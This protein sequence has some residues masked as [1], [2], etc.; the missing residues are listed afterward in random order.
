MSAD[1]APHI[2]V[3]IAVYVGTPL[4]YQKYRHTA[5]CFRPSNREAPMIIHIVGPNMDYQLETRN[6]YEPTSSRS[7]AKEVPVGWIRTP[8]TKAQLAPL[9]YQTPINNTS[10]EFNCQTWVGDVLRRLVQAGYLTR[11]DCENG[12][13]GMIDAT[14][15]AGDE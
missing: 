7:F 11:E 6:N 14:L 13:D 9:I 12:I 1:A 15:E 2:K 8:M 10:R 3:S 4:D 5:L